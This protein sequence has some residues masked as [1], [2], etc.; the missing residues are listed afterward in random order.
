MASADENNAMPP[1]PA[2]PPLGQ[3]YRDWVTH[4]C[5]GQNWSPTAATTSADT[6]PLYCINVGHLDEPSAMSFFDGTKHSHH[7][8]SK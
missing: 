8:C 2:L 7:V 1:M 6:P 3:R 5:F 4:F